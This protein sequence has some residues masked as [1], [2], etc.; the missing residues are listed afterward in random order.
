MSAPRASASW[1]ARLAIGGGVLLAVLLQLLP[2]YITVTSALKARSDLSSQWAFPIGAWHWQNFATAVEEGHILRAIGNS[3]IV[4][5][6]TTVLVCL[7]GA[8]AAY[9]LARRPTRGNRLVF[10]GIVGLIMVPPLSILVPLYSMMNQLKAV[11]TFWGTILVMVAMQ[12]PLAIF[13]YASFMRGLP[14]SIEEAASVDGANAVQ[15]LF[16]IVFP[17]LKPVTA[18]VVILTG[19]AVWNEYAISVYLMRSPEMRTIAPA[20]GTF[21]ATSSSDLG[22]AAAASLLSVLPV[23]VVYLLLQR[24]FIKGMVAGAEK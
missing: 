10:A 14:L 11:N 1:G 24:Y 15:L 19:V 9:P 22:A 7:L 23:L 4:T 18:T 17:M 5:G 2:F 6:S 16:R 3:A 20:I 12:L 8:L 13:L 21:F